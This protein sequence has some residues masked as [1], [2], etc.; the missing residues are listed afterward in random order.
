MKDFKHF[1]FSAVICLALAFVC[2]SCDL[3]QSDK[4]ALITE[5]A[6]AAAVTGMIA[7]EADPVTAPFAP[8][9]IKGLGDA[10]TT[11]IA[12]LNDASSTLTLQQVIDLAFS[13]DPDL[14][15]Y[16]AI[17]NFCLPILMDI[18]AVKSALNIA[19][20]NINPTVKADVIAFFTGIQT[21]LGNN[22]TQAQLDPLLKNNP[23]L[24]KAAK[25][26]GVGKFNPQNLINSLKTE[27]AKK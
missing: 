23:R 21:G 10:S 2:T 8:I 9:I 3:S 17:V 7:L 16:Q 22:A 18:P 19:V 24:A 25:R 11:A 5:G 4:E 20:Q 14:A 26:L 12:I 27:A 15:K 1:G 13:Q 6:E